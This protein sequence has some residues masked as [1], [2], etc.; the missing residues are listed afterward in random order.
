MGHGSRWS[1]I[2]FDPGVDSTGVRDI[3]FQKRFDE[4]VRRGK[5]D[6]AVAL[7]N[8][9]YIRGNYFSSV[10]SFGAVV[11]GFEQSAA[12][13]ETLGSIPSLSPCLFHSEGGEKN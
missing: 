2:S 7:K 1:E 8:F 3:G 11:W 10:F 6:V 13:L 9:R 4:V 12:E 5:A